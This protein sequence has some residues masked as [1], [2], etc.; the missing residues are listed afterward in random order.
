MQVLVLH[1]CIFATTS[2]GQQHRLI[3]AYKQKRQ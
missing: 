1:M 2:A 3:A